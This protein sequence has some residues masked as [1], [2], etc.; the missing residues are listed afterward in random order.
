MKSNAYDI[1]SNS[2]AVS[3]S[4]T[5]TTEAIFPFFP[6]P[7]NSGWLETAL[8]VTMAPMIGLL[9]I[10]LRRKLERRFRH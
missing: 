9:F 8:R 6:L 10:T 1:I 3:E 5:R 4:I 2:T 7:E